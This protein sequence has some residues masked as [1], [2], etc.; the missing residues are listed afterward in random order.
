[1]TT[2]FLVLLCY[3]AQEYRHALF[4]S[5]QASSCDWCCRLFASELKKNI[6]FLPQEAFGKAY[7]IPTIDVI[8]VRHVSVVNTWWCSLVFL[9]FTDCKPMAGTRQQDWKVVCEIRKRD[10]WHF[11]A[12][13]DYRVAVQHLSGLWSKAM[14][15]VLSCK[16]RS[17]VSKMSNFSNRANLQSAFSREWCPQNPVKY[18]VWCKFK[19][20]FA[21]TTWAWIQDRSVIVVWS[22]FV[23][24]AR[25]F[26]K[27]A[28]ARLWNIQ[29]VYVNVEGVT[30]IKKWLY[31]HYIACFEQAMSAP[32]ESWLAFV[33]R[34][35]RNF[36]LPVHTFD[37]QFDGRML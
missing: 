36:F 28:T 32:Y 3:G 7:E 22:L 8:H 9:L 5:E 17:T 12:F 20:R 10:C 35:F 25:R 31:C 34:G 4:A 1:M 2:A 18:I 11:L 19:W 27:I 24:T 37:K 6:S 33:A 29:L 21:C 23:A 13:A 14:T 15:D 26:G 16:R 30:T